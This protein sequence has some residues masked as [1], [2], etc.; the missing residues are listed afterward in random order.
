MQH[1]FTRLS[2]GLSRSAAL[3]VLLLLP[4]LGWG[5]VAFY[6]IAN[7]TGNNTATLAATSSA[8]G[9]TASVLSKTGISSSSSNNNFRATGWPTNTTLGGY[10]SFMLMPASGVTMNL[11]SLTYGVGSSGSGPANYQWRSSVDNYASAINTV[12]ASGAPAGTTLTLPAS[13]TGITTAVTFRLY[14]Y[15][16]SAS[17]GTGGLAGDLTVNG[18]ATNGTPTPTLTVSPTAL[19]G[20]TYVVGSGPSASQTYDLSGSNLTPAAGNLTVTGSTNYEVSLSNTAGFGASVTVPYTSST[21]AATPIYVRLKTGLAIN[22]YNGET[23]A[24]SGGGAT[25]NVT[26]S[27]SVTAPAAATIT[28]GT[29]SPI[30]VCATTATDVT[31]NFTT[32][33]GPTGTYTAQLSSATGSFTMPTVLATVSSTS[34]SQTVT[35]PAGTASGTGY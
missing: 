14:G 33:N 15:S 13:F 10:I 1:L 20:F 22:T 31:V 9:V 11:T 28:T 21:L 25:T 8:V 26:V 29:V 19:T 12:S 17:S 27:G 30:P 3:L 35:I 6:N 16:A 2:T 24:N 23:I 4:L 18:T 34:S 32:A 5:Q 7:G